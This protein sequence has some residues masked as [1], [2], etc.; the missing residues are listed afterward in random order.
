M[1]ILKMKLENFQG[2][3]ELELDPRGESCATM[4]TM[5]LVRVPY[6]MPLPG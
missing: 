1:K 3:K 2:V 4:V 6:T 5:E